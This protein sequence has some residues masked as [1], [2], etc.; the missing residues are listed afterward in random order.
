[1]EEFIKDGALGGYLT[2]VSTSNSRICSLGGSAE[3]EDSWEKQSNVLDETTAARQ[4]RKTISKPAQTLIVRD[5][6]GLDKIRRVENVPEIRRD[7][8]GF[9][10]WKDS[11]HLRN[12]AHIGST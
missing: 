7:D 10:G 11:S 6:V 5:Y 1:M 12:A 2:C 8:I 9:L 3:V 4:K